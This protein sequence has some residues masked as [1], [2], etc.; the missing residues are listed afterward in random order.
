MLA[1]PLPEVMDQTPPLLTSV[2]G[3]V[4]EFIQ[5]VAA[6]PPIAETVGSKFTVIFTLFDS[7][8]PIQSDLQL[9]L[10]NRLYQAEMLRIPGE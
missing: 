9:T 3:G 6:P 10:D 1:V 7:A 4:A 8:A 5:T 2:K